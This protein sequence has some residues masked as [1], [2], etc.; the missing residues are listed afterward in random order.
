MET[1]DVVFVKNDREKEKITTKNPNFSDKASMAVTADDLFKVFVSHLGK[2][3]E[4]WYVALGLNEWETKY[5]K[6][7]EQVTFTVRVPITYDE[8]KDFLDA[9]EDDKNDI[10]PIDVKAKINDNW[11]F[12]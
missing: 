1:A 11:L 3:K 4:S 8:F 5:I 2:T 12:T 7:L 10:E 6:P 9:Q